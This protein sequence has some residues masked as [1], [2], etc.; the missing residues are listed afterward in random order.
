MYY[1]FRMVVQFGR[2]AALVGLQDIYDKLS[3]N[4][5]LLRYWNLPFNREKQ[6]LTFGLSGMPKSQHSLG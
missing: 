1:L 6:Y 3:G 2:E 5:Y 4:Q